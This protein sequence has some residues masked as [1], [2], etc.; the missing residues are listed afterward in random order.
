MGMGEFISSKAHS[1]F[2][3]QE[4]A[5]EKWELENHK[6]GEINEMVQIYMQRGMSEE[7]AQEVVVRLARYSEFFVDVMMAEELGMPAYQGTDVGD[8][9]REGAVMFLSFAVAGSLPLLGFCVVPYVM[10]SATHQLVFKF[11]CCITAVCLLV[12]G[13]CKGLIVTG[14]RSWWASGLEML[15][16]GGAC[17]GIAYEIG[18]LVS[19][20]SQGLVLPAD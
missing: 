8:S 15:F 17:A 20:M 16:L 10:P 5:R 3:R 19:S 1:D 6:E 13:A 4:R 14:S 11:A 12:V 2:V 9:L 7:D 18:D